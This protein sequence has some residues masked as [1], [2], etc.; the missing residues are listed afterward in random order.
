MNR[1]D[2]LNGVTYR[3]RPGD[4]C[5]AEVISLTEDVVATNVDRKAHGDVAGRFTVSIVIEGQPLEQGS[6]VDV[7]DRRVIRA[8]SSTHRLQWNFY[9]VK[10]PLQA[11]TAEETRWFGISDIKV[12]RAD[13]TYAL[14]SNMAPRGRDAVAR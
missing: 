10:L 12:R 4:C 6:Q 1:S 5:S 9:R 2:P 3:R 13:L 14:M 11:T 8:S 7:V